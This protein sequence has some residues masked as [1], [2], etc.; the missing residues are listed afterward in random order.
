MLDG[1]EEWLVTQAA[2]PAGSAPS[3][4]RK[5]SPCLGGQAGRD[6]DAQPAELRVGVEQPKGEADFERLPDGE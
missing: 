6:A 1:A 2:A 3:A 4:A 5:V